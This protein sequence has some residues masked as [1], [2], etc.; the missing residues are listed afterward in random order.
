MGRKNWTPGPN[1]RLCADH[2]V[3]EC[4]D[5]RNKMNRLHRGAIPTVFAHLQESNPM[6]HINMRFVL[7]SAQG[8]NIAH[9]IQSFS[10]TLESLKISIMFP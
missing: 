10:I 6:L 8:L 9:T 3:K 1:S 7:A 5:T 2:F 4:I